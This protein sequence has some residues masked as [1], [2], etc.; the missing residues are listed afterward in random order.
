MDV[1]RYLVTGGCR[2]GKSRYA[3]ELAGSTRDGCFIATAQALDEEMGL[4]IRKHR[5]ERGP[6]WQ[7]I[8]EP[9]RLAKAVSDQRGRPVIVVDCVTLWVSNWLLCADSGERPE[10]AFWQEL[11]DLQQAIADAT[12]RLIIVTNEVGWGIVPDNSLARR[13]RDWAGIAN[14]R[15]AAAVD[16]VILM[17]SGLPVAVKGKSI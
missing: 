3:L 12:S 2:S 5:Q 16:H 13:F 8:E 9:F 10:S 11:D 14:Q 15:I 7:T 17:V 1:G 4:R 6:H